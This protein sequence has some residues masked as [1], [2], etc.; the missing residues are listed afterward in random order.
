MTDTA[1]SI[2]T[3]L[4]GLIAAHDRRGAVDVALNAVRSDEISLG[5][6]YDLIGD[7]LID[8]GA[9]WHTGKTAVWQE[10]YATAVVRTIVEA[11]HE[12]VPAQSASPNG[13]TVVLTTPPDEYHDLG[14]RMLAD[15]FELAGW[16]VHLLGPSLPPGE[17]VAAVGALGPD[18]VVLST[19]THYHRLAA[20]RYVDELRAAAPAVRVWVGGPAFAHSAEGWSPE[21]LLDVADVPTLAERL[22]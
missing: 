20:R 12:F 4:D 7:L 17:L 10:H 19:S 18:A 22:R 13:L 11:C 15:R 8:V 21:E 6:L 3:R 5:A 16:R 2:R 1:A 9:S 14:L